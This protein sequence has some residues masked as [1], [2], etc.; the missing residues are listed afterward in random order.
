MALHDNTWWRHAG[1]VLTS[2][3]LIV[4]VA[5]PVYVLGDSLERHEERS[6]DA[7]ATDRQGSKWSKFE[8]LGRTLLSVGIVTFLFLPEAAIVAG[9]VGGLIIVVAGRRSRM[10][11]KQESE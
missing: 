7:L 3:L 8:T 1:G 2:F 11:S 5:A 10:Q 6:T 4:V 9:I